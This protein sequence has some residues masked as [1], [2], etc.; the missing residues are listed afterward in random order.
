ML[1]AEMNATEKIHPAKIAIGIMMIQKTVNQ[2][3]TLRNTNGFPK[4]AFMTLTGTTE[5]ES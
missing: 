3:W 2:P 5:G 1:R 4:N